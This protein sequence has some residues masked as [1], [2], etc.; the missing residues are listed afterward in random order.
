V[1]D[2][3]EIQNH[4]YLSRIGRHVEFLTDIEKSYP[5]FLTRWLYSPVAVV[6]PRQINSLIWNLWIFFGKSFE[7]LVLEEEHD[8]KMSPDAEEERYR[9]IKDELKDVKDRLKNL[10]QLMESQ[11]H[12]RLRSSRSSSLPGIAEARKVSSPGDDSSVL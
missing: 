7:K 11:H 2:I 1:G 6:Y 12:Q 9:G 10:T 8:T 3:S 5:T 4:A